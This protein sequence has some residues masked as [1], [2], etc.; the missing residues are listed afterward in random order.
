MN[1]PSISLPTKPY[2]GPP[3]AEDRLPGSRR[4][5]LLASPFLFSIVALAAGYY[6]FKQLPQDPAIPYGANLTLMA[7]P[8]ETHPD[9]AR[10]FALHCANCHGPNGDGKGVAALA[11]PARYFG[12]EKYKF[13]NTTNAIPSD[14]DLHGLL[15]RGIPGSAMP[16][17]QQLTQAQR[18]ALVAHVRQLT[19]RGTYERLLQKAKK[20]YEDGGDDVNP[21]KIAKAADAACAVGPALAIPEIRPRP[22]SLA[23]G[24]EIFNKVCAAC[25]GPGGLGDGPQTKDPKFVNENG[26]PATPRNLTSGLYKGGSDDKHLYARLFL[27]I[28]GTPMPASGTAYKPEEIADLVVFVRNLVKPQ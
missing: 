23:K 11:I 19:W 21:S 6:G 14:D 16:D 20:D 12:F 17:F 26:S 1:E 7:T 3:P 25:H 9:G 27:G 18:D 22:E 10:L 24:Q 15:L 2:L 4:W 8:P 28:P 13:A 5:F